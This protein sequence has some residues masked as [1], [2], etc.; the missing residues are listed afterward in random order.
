LEGV[1]RSLSS[2][3]RGCPLSEFAID[4]SKEFVARLRIAADPGLQQ[5]SN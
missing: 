4:D 2:K 1:I 5:K 3:V